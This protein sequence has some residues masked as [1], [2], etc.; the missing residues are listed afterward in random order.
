MIQIFY[1]LLWVLPCWTE[2]SRATVKPFSFLSYFPSS[3]W[4]DYH[5]APWKNFRC[6]CLPFWLSPAKSASGAEVGDER[7]QLSHAHGPTALGPAMA[8]AL[9]APGTCTCTHCSPLSCQNAAVQ[10][11][12]PRE[13]AGTHLSYF[14]QKIFKMLNCSKSILISTRWISDGGLLSFCQCIHPRQSCQKLPSSGKPSR[15]TAKV[16]LTLASRSPALQFPRH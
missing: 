11:Q 16:P 6:I 4:P 3:S 7:S 13:K 1:C 14:P 15:H 5:E 8:G 9:L 10:S 12:H 2:T